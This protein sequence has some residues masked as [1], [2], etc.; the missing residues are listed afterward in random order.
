[1]WRLDPLIWLGLAGAGALYLHADRLDAR[2]RGGPSRP[3]PRRCFVAGLVAVVVALQSPIDTAAETSFA[4]HMVQHLLLTMVAAPLLVLGAP[5]T[6]TLR[7]WPGVGRRRVLALLHSPPVRVLAN[8]LVAW[9]LFFGVMWVTHMSG[10]YE[11][12]LRSAS[13]HSAEHLAYL[14]TAL[15]FWTP[16]AGVEPT[17]SR[18]SYPARILYLFL[19]MPAMAFLGLAIFSAHLVLYP[20]YAAVEGASR[21]LADQRLAGALMWNAGMFLIVPALAFVLFDWMR[22]EDREARRVDER[23]RRRRAG[24]WPGIQAV[25][26]QGRGRPG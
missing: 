24:P 13:I 1:M 12:T 19:A 6:L 17:P 21:A 20:T 26:D 14:A 25:G 3:W 16:V 7:A 22:A 2:R 5:V 9:T 11:R 15:L 10:L 18:L 4:M 8:P 23:L